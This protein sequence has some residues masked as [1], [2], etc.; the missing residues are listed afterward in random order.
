[1]TAAWDASVS[2]HPDVAADAAHRELHQPSADGAEKLAAR[3]RG[4]LVPDAKRRRSA[5]RAAPAAE[6]SAAEL[7]TLAAARF[8]ERSFAAVEEQMEEK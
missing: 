8:G 4:V 1:V 3:A 6:P 2:V 7:C 5:L